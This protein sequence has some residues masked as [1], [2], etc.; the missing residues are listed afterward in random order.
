MCT[1]IWWVRPVSRSQAM[2]LAS[3]KL[4]SMRQ[5]VTALRPRSSG[6]IAM[7]SRSVGW[8]PS[9]AS[10]MPAARSGPAP[11]EGDVGA[12]QRQGAAVVGEEPGQALVRPVRLGRDQQA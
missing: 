12:R 4:S 2:R 11:D 9:G 3:P 8:R 6:T 10:T 1:R 7:R 5:W